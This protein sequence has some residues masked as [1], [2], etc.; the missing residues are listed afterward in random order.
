MKKGDILS[1]QIVE[2]NFPDSAYADCEGEKVLIKK[3]ILG[4]TV[5]FAVTKKRKGKLEGRVLNVVEKSLLEDNE[6]PCIHYE[7]CGGC[8]Y[9]T[10]SYENQLKLKDE[11]LRALMEGATD[12]D[13]LWEGVIPSPKY[14]A[15]RNKMEFSFGDEKKD[16][17]LALGMHKKGS[18]YDIVNVFGCKILFSP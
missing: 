12:N 5:E 2:S 18:H 14:L 1:G 8:T 6:N 15:Y 9:Q 16:G 13:F 11:Q 3:G 10:L 4:Q 7:T 17:D